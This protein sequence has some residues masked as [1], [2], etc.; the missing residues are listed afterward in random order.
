[1]ILRVFSF[2]ERDIDNL[3]EGY[4]TMDKDEIISTLN[5]LIETC[6]DGEAGFRSCIDDVQAPQFKTLF[7][8]RL[9]D[10]KNAAAELQEIV[11]SLGG[12]PET[13]SSFSGVLH[14]RWLDIKSIITG[15]DD[16]AILEEC[17]RGQDLAR[18]NY[19]NALEK[20]LP[21]EIRVSVERQYQDVIRN[22]DHIKNL[23]DELQSS[24][25]LGRR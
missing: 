3:T 15:H 17:E 18:R 10:C 5:D 6:K 4:E 22:H 7:R 25:N 8:D 9:Q 24:K 21:P 13:R 20:V 1:M 11:R 12:D 19:R 14:R 16:L 23:H 2:Q